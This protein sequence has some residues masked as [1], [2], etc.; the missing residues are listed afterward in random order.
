MDWYPLRFAPI[1]QK[2]IWG[3][4][5]LEELYHRVLPE[6]VSI[7][8][9]WEI[10]DRP[11]GMSVVSEGPLKGLSLAELTARDPEGL[12]GDSQTL[13]GRFPLL[14]KILDACDVLSIQVHPP[15]RSAARLGGEPKTEMWYFTAATPGAEI[16]VGLRPGTTREE[17]EERT[18]NGTLAECLHRNPVRAGDAMFLPSGRVHALGKG[19]VLF[20]IQESSDTTYRAFDWNRVDP[21]GNPRKLHIP[22]SL[23]S[24]DFSDF[25]P[26]LVQNA[27]RK[28][29]ELEVRPLVANSKFSVEVRRAASDTRWDRKLNRC[30][31]LAVVSGPVEV[32]GAGVKVALMPGDFCLLPAGL[33]EAQLRTPKGSE[34][35]LAEPGPRCT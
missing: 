3:G 26:G 12:L 32:E 33:K 23:E 9:S 16:F 15:E 19:L 31:L 27:W 24:I 21:D 17:W 8:E 20:E 7:G 13:R 30:V 2:R 29:G 1:Y 11:E 14:A 28:E 34:W 6:G 22:E 18:R 5:R 35:L 25:T 10:S 4:R